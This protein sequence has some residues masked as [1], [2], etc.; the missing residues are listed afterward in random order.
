MLDTEALGMD[1]VRMR[2]KSKCPVIPSPRFMEKRPTWAI[3]WDGIVGRKSHTWDKD[4]ECIFCPAK[5]PE[6][7]EPR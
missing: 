3:C 4:G 7:W 5:D 6:T 2:K 1:R